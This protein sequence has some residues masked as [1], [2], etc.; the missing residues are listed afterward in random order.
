MLIILTYR[1]SQKRKSHFTI[2]VCTSSLKEISRVQFYSILKLIID[3]NRH[4][5]DDI[6]R[7]ETKS[8]MINLNIGVGNTK[9]NITVTPV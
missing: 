8:I 3:T 9:G 5:K 6:P 4:K 2:H 1:V 7:P